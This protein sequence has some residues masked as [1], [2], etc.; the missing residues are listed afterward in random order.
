[1]EGKKKKKRRDKQALIIWSVQEKERKRNRGVR[2][3]EL[4]KIEQAG[5]K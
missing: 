1:M 2:S 4:F 3:K 5:G